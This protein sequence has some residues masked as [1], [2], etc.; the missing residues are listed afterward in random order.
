M[1]RIAVLVASALIIAGLSGCH[2]HVT[3]HA[4]PVLSGHAHPGLARPAS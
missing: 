1:R 4:G 3:A 2:F